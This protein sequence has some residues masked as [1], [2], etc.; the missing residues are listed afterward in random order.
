MGLRKRGLKDEESSDIPDS[1]RDN[2]MRSGQKV[3]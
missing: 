1:D 2:F 3:Q